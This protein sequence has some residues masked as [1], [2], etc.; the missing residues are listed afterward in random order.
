MVLCELTI[1][2]TDKGESVS[3][4][5]ARCIDVIDRSGLLYQL[6][7]MGTILEGQ[8]AEVMD[9]VRRCFESLTVDC[10]RINVSI[11]IDYRAGESSRMTTKTDRIQDILGRSIAT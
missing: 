8:W 9:V 7:P 2:P 10:S 3:P 6:T 11:K 4:Y 1:F 5:V